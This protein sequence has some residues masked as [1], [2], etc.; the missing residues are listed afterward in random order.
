MKKLMI[1]QESAAA[2]RR[3]K[4]RLRMDGIGSAKVSFGSGV[5]NIEVRREQSI[6]RAIS[7]QLTGLELV[8]REYFGKQG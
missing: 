8:G 2:H 3:W 7:E 6:G 1:M 5:L 4:L